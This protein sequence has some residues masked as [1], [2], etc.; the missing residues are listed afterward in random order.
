MTRN[1]RRK[2]ARERLLRKQERIARAELGRQQDE[3]RAIVQRN[4]SEPRKREYGNI[5]SCLGGIEG[6]SHRGYVCRA[7]GA[8]PRATAIA[9]TAKARRNN[10]R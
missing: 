10:V 7:T 4:L 3:R 2:A 5:R 9:V 1:Q 6:Q 8:M